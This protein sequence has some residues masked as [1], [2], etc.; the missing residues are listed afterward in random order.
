[1]AAMRCRNELHDRSGF[2]SCWMQKV[3]GA[4]GESLLVLSGCTALQMTKLIIG[5][6][7]R[8]C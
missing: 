7:E 2:V 8:G 6:W 5:S 1:M 3:G 4:E